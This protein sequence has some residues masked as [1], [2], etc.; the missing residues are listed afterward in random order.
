MYIVHNWGGNKGLTAYRETRKADT[1]RYH[2]HQ[3]TGCFHDTE[4]V[5][6]SVRAKHKELPAQVRRHDFVTVEVIEQ[7]IVPM[8]TVHNQR[9]NAMHFL[10]V[11]DLLIDVAEGKLKQFM[12]QPE[13]GSERL[14]KWP[15]LEEERHRLPLLLRIQT[16]HGPSTRSSYI[17]KQAFD[18]VRT[19]SFEEEVRE[20][21]VAA[22]DLQRAFPNSADVNLPSQ[23]VSDNPTYPYRQQISTHSK[24]HSEVSTRT[25]R[26][27]QSSSVTY[28]GPGL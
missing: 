22:P 12:K 25:R 23:P 8:L 19:R 11:A 26:R 17:N 9:G 5:L 28:Q 14:D 10:G 18:D 13:R 15:M 16:D 1:K 3:D 24:Y 2:K 7:L 27:T 6:G 4:T 21:P 20:S